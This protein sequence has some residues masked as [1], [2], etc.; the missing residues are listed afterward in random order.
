MRKQI[1]TRRVQFDFPE[2][3]AASFQF[4]GDASPILR[5][6]RGAFES[7]TDQNGKALGEHIDRIIRSCKARMFF[8]IIVSDT[9]IVFKDVEQHNDLFDID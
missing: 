2:K 3:Q 1:K 4:E 5:Y 9:E 6:F 7:S 8:N